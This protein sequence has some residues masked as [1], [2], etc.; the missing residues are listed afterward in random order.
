MATAFDS[1]LEASAV[2]GRGVHL[3]IG[4]ALYGAAG[5]RDDDLQ[6]LLQRQD[7][8][9]RRFRIPYRQAAVRRME[10]SVGQRQRAMHGAAT[11]AAVSVEFPNISAW[12]APQLIV[13][14]AVRH[15][16]CA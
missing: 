3:V 16:R 4:G 11:A 1:V 6:R 12:R 2:K 8:G 9:G 14:R 13:E 5:P 10:A 15:P 7:P